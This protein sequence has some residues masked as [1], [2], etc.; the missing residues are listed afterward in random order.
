MTIKILADNN[1]VYWEILASHSQLHLLIYV[2]N[3][4]I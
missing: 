2:D 3:N 4:G 1:I